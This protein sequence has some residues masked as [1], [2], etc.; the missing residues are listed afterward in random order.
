MDAGL[1]I[2]DTLRL[3]QTQ[4]FPSSGEFAIPQSEE[5]LQS[6]F[7]CSRSQLYLRGSDTVTPGVIGQIQ[8][9]IKRCITGEPLQYILGKVFFYSREFEVTPDV[10]IPRP[11]TEILVEQVL[12]HEQKEHRFFADIGIGSG[13]IASILTESNPGWSAI[14]I[15]ISYKSLLVAKRNI[16]SAVRLLQGDLLKALREQHLFDFIVSNPPYISNDAIN[17]LDPGV[18][19]F[20][21]R[22]ALSGGKDGLDFYRYLSS[23]AKKFIV[24]Q[25]AMYCEIGYDQANSVRELF[26]MN[27]WENLGIFKDLGGHPRVIRAVVPE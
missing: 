6:I 4:L 11:D 15:D 14:G 7:R 8:S 24:P 22:H 27:G 19:N 25:G 10:L 3:I 5:I 23:E 17:S 18:K 16:H 9:I 21:P 2:N 26:F 1:N 20:E 13:I 12:L